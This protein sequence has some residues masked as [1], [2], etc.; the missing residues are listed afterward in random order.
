DPGQLAVYGQRFCTGLLSPDGRRPSLAVKPD[1]TAAY[2]DGTSYEIRIVRLSAAPAQ[3]SVED[4]SMSD[5]L[6]LTLLRRDT[7]RPELTAEAIAAFRERATR[8]P[9]PNTLGD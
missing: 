4:A 5:A 1:G 8:P 9:S 2:G 6:A 7:P 3:R